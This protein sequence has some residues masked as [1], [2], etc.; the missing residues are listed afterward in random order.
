MGNSSSSHENTW[1]SDTHNKLLI[2]DGKVTLLSSI[3]FGENGFT[4]N[5]EAGMVVQNVNV[6]DYYLSIFEAD[7]LDGEIPPYDL[8]NG[9]IITTTTTS[10]T[11]NSSFYPWISLLIITLFTRLHRRLKSSRK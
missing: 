8:V 2:V 6:A 3:N 1:L 7:W 9:P 4:N 5:R 10:K 11:T